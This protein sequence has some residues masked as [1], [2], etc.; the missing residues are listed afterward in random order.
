MHSTAYML[1]LPELYEH[2]A[3]SVKQC[4]INVKNTTENCYWQKNCGNLISIL[5]IQRV[6]SKN[7]TLIQNKIE[8][9]YV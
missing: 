6:T 5:Q 9:N 4:G 3:L 2:K 7:A 8:M 1:C